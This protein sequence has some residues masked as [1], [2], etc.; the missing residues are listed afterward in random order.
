MN[1]GEGEAN[2]IHDLQVS[3][4]NRFFPETPDSG[5]VDVFCHFH[6]LLRSSFKL[7]KKVGRTCS[8]ALQ[9]AQR[10]SSCFRIRTKFIVGAM[11]EPPVEPFLSVSSLLRLG[12]GT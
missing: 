5:L 3:L 7:C 9:T 12:V 2:L 11:L 4:A 6:L 10:S 1:V 8:V